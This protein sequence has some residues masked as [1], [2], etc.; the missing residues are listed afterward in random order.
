MR[1]R[2]DPEPRLVVHV[3]HAFSIGGL[4][5]GVVNLVNRLPRDRWRHAILALTDIS[6]EFATRIERSDVEYLALRKGPGHLTKLYP[7]IFRV[8]RQWRPAI[9]H[10]RNLAALEAQVPA[11]L[12]GV[13]VRI[14]GEHG[15]D[16]S[17]LAGKS[18]R[19]RLVRRLY[20]PFVNH[21]VALSHHIDSYLERRI[22]I[23]QSR[24]AHICNGVDTLRF[25]PAAGGSEPI[26]G[27][28]FRDPG[29]WLVGT[30]GRMQAVK[31]QI[32]LAEA[33]VRAVRVDPNARARMRL[34][35]VGD[36][37]LRDRVSRLL[38]DARAGDLAWLPGERADVA[39]IMRGLHCFA[40]P[41]LAEGISNTILEAMA[42][43]L[44]V[45]ATNVGG[46]P[47]LVESGLTGQLVPAADPGALAEAIL[48]YFHAPAMARRHGKAGRS[49]VERHFSLERMAADYERL[50]LE[51]L[52]PSRPR[53]RAA[54][55]GVKMI[56]T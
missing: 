53:R 38:E 44:P 3:V 9:V 31:D 8:L 41:S 42:S 22:G 16:V 32:N 48:A 19:Y 27:C 39:Q 21:Y 25:R 28:P 46:N 10:T 20:R 55:C 5:N 30:V 1:A 36:G 35:M 50:Y 40:L 47:D 26:P 13:P 49:R 23:P 37:P 24:I 18:N 45:V 2:A 52:G 6:D 14:H 54:P 33:F 4:E 17:D 7:R 43:G 56:N 51:L 12:A 11:W 29:L 34:V 15:W